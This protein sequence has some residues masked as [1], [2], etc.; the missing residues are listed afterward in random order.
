MQ[1][2]ACFVVSG[3]VQGVG[4]RATT[5]RV[6]ADL[7]LTGWVKNR[8]DGD[9]ELKAWGSA[10]SL[11]KLGEWLVKGPLM[12]RVTAVDRQWAQAVDAPQ[13]FTVV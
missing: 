5:Q 7:G 2:C 13:S 12:A 6:A 9:V 3:K 8:P 1:A 11:D 4:F 10:A